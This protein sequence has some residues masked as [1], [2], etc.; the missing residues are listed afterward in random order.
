MA[1][2]KRSA[3]QIEVEITPEEFLTATFP[4]QPALQGGMYVRAMA[5]QKLDIKVC[6]SA[7]TKV[8]DGKFVVTFDL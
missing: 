5:Q 7:T 6:K 8:I 4:S 3:K 2:V 1:K